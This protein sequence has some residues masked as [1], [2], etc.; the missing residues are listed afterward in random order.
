MGYIFPAYGRTLCLIFC[1]KNSRLCEF[2]DEHESLPRLLSHLQTCRSHSTYFLHFSARHWSCKTVV[3]EYKLR[4][5]YLV[6]KIVFL[7]C[8]AVVKGSFSFLDQKVLG[9]FKT[10]LSLVPLSYAI[11]IFLF[12]D[13]SCRL[14]TNA[15]FFFPIFF[16][17]QKNWI[18]FF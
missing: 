1:A 2:S 3:A 12:V 10:Y 5:S 17:N 15:C 11:S 13:V 7:Q 9:V 18:K 6:R 16:I 14:A 4:M 8:I